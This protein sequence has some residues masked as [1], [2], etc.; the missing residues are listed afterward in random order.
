VQTQ[1]SSFGGTH[2]LL[3]LCYAEP[4]TWAAH[5]CRLAACF[6]FTTL[7]D[8]GIITGLELTKACPQLV[9]ISIIMAYSHATACMHV[10]YTVLPPY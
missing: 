6:C 4:Q 7:W 8:Y 3:S 1:T 9:I 5:S 2:S 10:H